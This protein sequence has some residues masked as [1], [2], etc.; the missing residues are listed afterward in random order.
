MKKI[1]FRRAALAATLAVPM[2]ASSQVSLSVTIAPPPL[3]VYEQPAIP[4]DGYIWTPGYWSWDAAAGDYEWVP[5]T[6]VLPP[7]VGVLWTPGYWDFVNGGYGWHRGYWG[8]HVGYYGGLNYGYGYSGD[9][10]YGGRWERGHFRYNQAYNNVPR[11]RVHDVYDQPMH[12]HGSEARDSF[13]GGDSHFH[14]RPSPAEQHYQGAMHGGPTPEQVDH[15]RR[16]MNMPG[17]RLSNNHGVPPMAATA[18]PGG[19]GQLPPPAPRPAGDARPPGMAPP[20]AGG[21]PQGGNDGRP[22]GG[23]G[24]GPQDRGRDDP[25]QHH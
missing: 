20:Q 11:G 25:G 8:D 7:Q 16:A 2:L 15:E 5:G 22:E 10:Y 17:Q 18:R 12:D 6:W 21:R 14:G 1:H 24:H 4:G 23:S 9:G 13:N 3:P 19:F